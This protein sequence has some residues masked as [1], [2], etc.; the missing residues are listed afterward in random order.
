MRDLERQ[1]LPKDS[2]QR[3]L[4]R[5]LVQLTD[6]VLKGS[7]RALQTLDEPVHLAG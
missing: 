5:Q 3:Y 6:P 7:P 4:S 2:K 1:S